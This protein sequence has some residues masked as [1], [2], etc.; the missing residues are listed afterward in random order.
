MVAGGAGEHRF[1]AEHPRRRSSFMERGNLGVV[2]EAEGWVEVEAVNFNAEAR[3]GG[4]RR[5][6]LEEV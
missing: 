1:D 6:V 3:R 2:A 5:G 4:G